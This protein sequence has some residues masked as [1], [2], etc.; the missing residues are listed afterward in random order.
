M[1]DLWPEP[2]PGAPYTS[3]SL[4]QLALGVA[5]RHISDFARGLVP[6][7]RHRITYDGMLL[8][9]ALRLHQLA[10]NV[11]DAAIVLEREDGTSWDEIADTMHVT[12]TVAKDRWQPAEQR[13]HDH[14][15]LAATPGHHHELPGTLTDRPEDIARQLDDWVT[16]HREPRDPIHG[17][18]PVT[19]T[20]E[21]MHPMLELL[22]LRGQQDRLRQTHPEPPPQLLASILEREAIV[23]AALADHPDTGAPEHTDDTA[24]ARA[25]A[26]QLRNQAAAE[27]PTSH[28]QPEERSRERP[29]DP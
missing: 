4:A 9:D 10:Q 16:H 24:Q 20:L 17:D 7:G 6:T 19:D 23:H 15:E 22:H 8:A 21:T 13:W 3:R 2:V 25:Y 18:H 27:P 14:V 11:L 1:S 26:A 5:A 28:D 29:S 12:P